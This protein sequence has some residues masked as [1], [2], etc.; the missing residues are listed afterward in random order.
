MED[1]K[2]GPKNPK[3]AVYDGHEIKIYGNFGDFLHVS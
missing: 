2:N 1:I 3:T